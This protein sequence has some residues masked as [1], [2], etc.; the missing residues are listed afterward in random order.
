MLLLR[1]FVRIGFL[2]FVIL[3]GAV[4]VKQS[5]WVFA[6]IYLRV[7]NMQKLR[8]CMVLEDIL[9]SFLHVLCAEKLAIKL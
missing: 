6:S 1:R 8:G 5:W 2:G 7:G 4:P 9:F 3:P